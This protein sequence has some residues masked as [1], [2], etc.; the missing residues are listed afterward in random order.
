[1]T[2]TFLPR[3]LGCTEGQLYTMATGAVVAALLA[4]AGSHAAQNAGLAGA[5]PA[6]SPVD[7]PVV[8]VPTTAPVS[9]APGIVPGPVPAPVIS[10]GGEQPPPVPLPTEWVP[11][12]LPTG[13]VVFA[14]IGSPGAPA[15]LAV[16]PDGRVFVTTDNGT[17]QGLAGPSKVFELGADGRQMGAVTITG[18]PRDH[19]YGLRGA[20]VDPVD[21]SV[22][23][24]DVDTSSVIRIDAASHAQRL[25]V[26]V[27]NVQPCLQTLN[28]APCEPGLTDFAPGLSALLFDKAGNLF[29]ADA[30]QGTIWR[31]S[32]GKAT[33]SQWYSSI[34]L[35]TGDGP[36][37]LAFSSTGS[38]LFTA[39]STFDTSNGNGG[40]L[41]SLAIGTDGSAG[42]RTLLAG[43]PSG[44]RPGAVA[45]DPFGAVYV[46]ARGKGAIVAFDAGALKPF[47]TTGSPIPLDTPSGLLFQNG[48]LLVTNGTASKTAASWAVLSFPGLVS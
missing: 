35:A 12:A 39:G 6:S 42:A 47:T 38:L 17:F 36:A 24:S 15:G 10:S 1:M 21:A 32:A 28:V 29:I 22:F 4:T 44:D 18:Q 40:G 34:D 13:P 33:L 5:P 7:A 37:G 11:I 45:A 9:P 31:L 20:A 43:F 16:A 27:P 41:Y 26:H 30:G 46:I 25:V 23:V 19:G 48:R 8:T 14:R 3:R 2:R